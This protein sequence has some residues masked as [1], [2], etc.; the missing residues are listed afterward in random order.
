[1][2]WGHLA[3]CVRRRRDA[4]RMLILRAGD[5]IMMDSTQGPYRFDR[6]VLD[7]LNLRLTADGENIALEPKS[8]RLL[9]F[10]IENRRRV[11]SKDEIMRV[12]WED[13]AVT[14]NALTRAVTLIRKA[15]GDDPKQPRFIETVPTVGYRFAAQVIERAEALPT[16]PAPALKKFPTRWMVTSVAAILAM[17]CASVWLAKRPSYTPRRV[18]AIRQITRSVAADLWPSFSPDGSQMAFSSNR[19]GQYEIYV[20]SLAPDGAERQITADGQENIEPAWS[21]DGRYLAYVA[22]QHGGIKL[23]PASGGPTRLL[24]GEGDSPQWSPNGRTLAIRLFS[25]NL[26]P[27]PEAPAPPA[28]GSILALIAVE[29]GPRGL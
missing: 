13:V 27:T 17:V 8:F 19:S 6:F 4:G 11:V 5:E 25:G 28:P 24:T 15:L 23:I 9:Q 10:L 26:N 21:P 22:R 7:P 2:A 20:R 18:V 16:A 1:L 3:V 14:D 29:G 12:V